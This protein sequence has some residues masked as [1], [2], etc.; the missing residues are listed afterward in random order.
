MTL[1]L[2]AIAEDERCVEVPGD[3]VQGRP[4]RKVAHR[5]LAALVSEKPHS[6]D[7]TE[8][9]LL[10]YE[11]AVQR[12][13]TAMPLLPARFATAIENDSAVAQLLGERQEE[14]LQAIERVRGAVELG[15]RAEWLA[16]EVDDAASA[17][18]AGTKYLRRRLEQQHRGDEIA[19]T[20]Q[21]TFADLVRASTVNLMSGPSTALIASYLVAAADVEEFLRR[22]RQLEEE[23]ADATF[24]C[25]GPWPPYSFS[26]PNQQ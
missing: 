2:Y 5:R 7:P 6:L 17:E 24:V 19:R 4:L 21:L 23:V 20:V 1:L 25:T 22:L 18:D 15:L 10:D 12:L 9:T 16:S 26:N 11:Q 14:F 8:S 13:M 3:G